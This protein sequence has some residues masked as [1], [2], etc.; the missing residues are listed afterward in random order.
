M[1]THPTEP[2]FSL[3]TSSRSLAMDTRQSTAV[4]LLPRPAPRILA[5]LAAAA[6]VLASVLAAAAQP[7]GS[8][9]QWGPGWM[10]A[11]P[12]PNSRFVAIDAGGWQSI[13]LKA[14]GSVVVWDYLGAGEVPWSNG[15][16]VR[17]ASGEAHLLAL[18]SDGKIEAWGF[19]GNGECSVPTPN[20]GFVAIA[21]GG[22]TE[23]CDYCSWP[24]GFSL[25]LRADGSIAAWGSNSSGQ[26][27]VPAPN[28]GYLAVAAG[29]EHS[30][31][32]RADGSIVAWGSNLYGQCNVP[33][34]NGGFVA[35]A[36]G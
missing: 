31:G 20:S 7:T 29:G 10:D 14:D 24:H 4:A 25:G 6:A 33:K 36:A 32:L 19:N 35:I 5:A 3:F 17:V 23:S 15:G 9:V 13:A 27:N 8:V 28:T 26:C 18:R 11:P 34:P 16:F 21:G 2:L 22:F 12:P 30:L 1:R